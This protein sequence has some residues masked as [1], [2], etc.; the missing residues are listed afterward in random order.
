MSVPSVDL[1]VPLAK[2]LGVS[3]LELLDGR[4]Q[5]DDTIAL[6]RANALLQEALERQK[7]VIL[8]KR[9]VLLFLFVFLLLSFWISGRLMWN[10]GLLLDGRNMGIADIYYGEWDCAMDWLRYALLAVLTGIA[11]VE[12]IKRE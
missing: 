5:E 3:A 9:A 6:E 2:V 1:I 8:K 10:Q 7:K 12:G 11:L 4:Q